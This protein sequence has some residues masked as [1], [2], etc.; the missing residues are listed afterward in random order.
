MLARLVAW[1]LVLALC[2][3]KTWKQLLV[4]TKVCFVGLVTIVGAYIF[5]CNQ[6]IPL[7]L[8]SLRCFAGAK[9]WRRE[10]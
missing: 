3:G 6:S 1:G 7:I 2:K 4:L 8:V 9:G 10:T 5:A